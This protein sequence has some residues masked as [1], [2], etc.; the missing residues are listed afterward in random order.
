MP[1]LPRT[2]ADFLDA[3]IASGSAGSTLTTSGRPR[4]RASQACDPCRSRKVKCDGGDP[5]GRCLTAN[6]TCFFQEQQ[7]HRGPDKVPGARKRRTKAQ[8]RHDDMIAAGILPPTASPPLPV[9]NPPRGKRLKHEP[10]PTLH[11]SSSSSPHEST[12]F[13][14]NPLLSWSD[15]PASSSS[16]FRSRPYPEHSAQSYSNYPLIN[17][18]ALSDGVYVYPYFEQQDDSETPEYNAQWQWANATSHERGHWAPSHSTTLT[19]APSIDFYRK[20]WWDNLL[21]AYAPED[22]RR[23]E[24]LSIQEIIHDFRSL[25]RHANQILSFIHMPS[26]LNKLARPESRA[27]LQPSL[28]ISVLALSSLMQG[29]G[30]KKW[31][32][33]RRAMLL[34][35]WAQGALEAAINVQC[36]DPTLAHAALLL[37]LFEVSP[38]EYQSRAR[39]QAAL[40]RLDSLV[41]ALGLN[42]MDRGHPCVSSFTSQ[43]APV[44]LPKLRPP[45]ISPNDLHLPQTPS[46]TISPQNHSPRYEYAQYPAQGQELYLHQSQFHSS[47]REVTRHHKYAQEHFNHTPLD[48]GLNSPADSDESSGPTSCTCADLSLGRNPM[49]IA[50]LST[51]NGAAEDAQVSVGFTCSPA[52]NSDW[53]DAMIERESTRQVVWGALWLTAY[54]GSHQAAWGLERTRFGCGKPAN[55]AV[56]FPGEEL[57]LNY[58]YAPHKGKET[59]WALYCRA[60][61]LWNACLEVHDN[62]PDVDQASAFAVQVWVEVD[63]ITK[64]LDRHPCKTEVGYLWGGRSI[65]QFA[66]MSVTY[67]YSRFV[68]SISAGQVLPE[69]KESEEWA[70]HLAFFLESSRGPETFRRITTAMP[71]NPFLVWY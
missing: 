52:W 56:L 4:V 40:V 8:K 36:L 60:L 51:S 46:S 38:H 42:A 50:G 57:H 62:K 10:N 43:S 23:D 2:P 68:P 49:V 58:G 30:A 71:W 32:K 11:L 67:N 69:R 63:R 21:R 44:V 20:S 54:H 25:F 70:K 59:V 22:G 48:S 16:Q 12:E 19:T 33:R 53:T 55:F 66:R 7:R 17:D 14:P 1:S 64:A 45:R 29:T 28:V 18:P 13:D 3:P 34:Y 6:M 5:C 65:L 41:L 15:P 39:N 31:H 9:I 61:L 37:A 27:K 26:F 24:R 47:P 35:E